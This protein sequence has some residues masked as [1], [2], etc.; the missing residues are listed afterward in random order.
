MFSEPSQTFVTLITLKNK[1]LGKSD[2]ILLILQMRKIEAD[3]Q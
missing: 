1:T 2:I 3:T